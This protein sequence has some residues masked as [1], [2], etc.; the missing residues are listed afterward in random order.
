MSEAQVQD[1]VSNFYEKRYSGNGYLFHEAITNDLLASAYGKILDIG[2]GTGFLMNLRPDLNISGIDISQ[3]MIDK[4]PMKDKCLVGDAES[5]ARYYPPNTFD[6]VICRGLL[7]HLKNPKRA[8]AQM[9]V[10]LKTGGKIA[11]LETNSSFLNRGPR[12][13]LKKTKRFSEDHVNFE[14]EQLENMVLKEFLINDIKFI[15]FVAY[16]LIGFPDFI[17]L[18]IPAPIAERLIKLDGF[19]SETFVKKLAFNVLIRGEK[20]ERVVHKSPNEADY[21]R[22]IKGGTL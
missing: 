8:L 9:R 20:Y 10:V 21:Q 12:R 4:N 18:P 16:P 17:D 7:H 11:L 1:Y 14:F 5:V 19:L 15:G 2:C 13:F 3:G 22:I 6:F